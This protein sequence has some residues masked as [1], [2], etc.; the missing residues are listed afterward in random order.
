LLG[1]EIRLGVVDGEMGFGDE[2]PVDIFGWENWE[3]R[4]AKWVYNGDDRNTLAVWV[5]GRLVHERKI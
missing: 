3:E 2:G 5:K 1:W 4:V